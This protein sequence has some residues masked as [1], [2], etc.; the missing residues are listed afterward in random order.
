M[1][2]LCIMVIVYFFVIL[3]NQPL[4]VARADLRVLIY[5]YPLRSANYFLNRPP[6]GSEPAGRLIFVNTLIAT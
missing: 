4:R 3:Y 2:V 1:C 6:P 5:P